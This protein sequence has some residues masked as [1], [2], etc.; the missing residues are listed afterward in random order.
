MATARTVRAW[1][2]QAAGSDETLLAR[3]GPFGTFAA[4]TVLW[5]AGWLGVRRRSDRLT[6]AGIRHRLRAIAGARRSIA[7]A[8]VLAAGTAVLLEGTV[9]A[10]APLSLEDGS[11]ERASVPAAPEHWIGVA[12]P[13]GEGDRVTLLGFAEPALDLT[14]PPRGP[15]R[16]G[17]AVLVRAARLPVI[18]HLASA[19]RQSPGKA[20][21]SKI[22]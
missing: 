5:E 8:A 7:D 19:P 11:G 2:R 21:G 15:R 4:L 6:E 18:A 14:R 10:L 12:G 17:R 16:P 13:A 3:L 9:S 22:P 1:L 20:E